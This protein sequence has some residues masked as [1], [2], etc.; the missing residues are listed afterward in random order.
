MDFI[1]MKSKKEFKFLITK[2]LCMVIERI[3]WNSL[4]TMKIEN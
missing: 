3:N 2:G 4:T 1:A